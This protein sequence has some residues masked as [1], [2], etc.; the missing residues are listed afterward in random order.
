MIIQNKI[1]WTMWCFYYSQKMDGVSC[2]L[3]CYSWLCD[4]KF[5][6]LHIYTKSI[7][8]FSWWKPRSKKRKPQILRDGIQKI[9]SFIKGKHI[10]TI[11]SKNKVQIRWTR[12]RKWIRLRK[13][14]YKQNRNIFL[15]KI[16][17]KMT[18]NWDNSK[19]NIV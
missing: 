18:A 14:V 6:L 11:I 4:R 3:K 7:F 15:K 16:I 1:I 8:F 5:V 2:F 9:G 19:R 17:I 10:W 12:Q 13:T